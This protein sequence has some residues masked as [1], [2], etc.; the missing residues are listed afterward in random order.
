M[1]ILDKGLNCFQAHD[2]GNANTQDTQGPR[3]GKLRTVSD[4]GILGL[5][6]RQASVNAKAAEAASLP[7][8]AGTSPTMKKSDWQFSSATGVCPPPPELPGK[9]PARGGLSQRAGKLLRAQLNSTFSCFTQK[10]ADRREWNTPFTTH[11]RAG[12]TTTLRQF[13]Q[14]MQSLEQTSAV[15]ATND[16][17]RLVKGMPAPHQ[18]LDRTMGA[19]RTQVASAHAIA[20]SRAG[21]PRV[22]TPVHEN[23]L[24]GF[25]QSPGGQ[26]LAAKVSGDPHVFLSQID[27]MAAEHPPAVA[28]AVS[29][30]LVSS[31]G[32]HDSGNAT[33]LGEDIFHYLKNVD[34]RAE[35]GNAKTHSEVFRDTHVLELRAVRDQMKDTLVANRCTPATTPIED[36]SSSTPL[37]TLDAKALRTFTQAVR[38]FPTAMRE[39]VR[40]APP[41]SSWPGMSDSAARLDAGNAGAAAAYMDALDALADELNAQRPAQAGNDAIPVSKET[42]GKIRDAQEAMI[43]F[44]SEPV[45]LREYDR[46]LK[47]AE[48]GRAIAWGALQRAATTSGFEDMLAACGIGGLNAAEQNNLRIHLQAGAVVAASLNAK[49]TPEALIAARLAACGPMSSAASFAQRVSDASA[50]L[51][52]VQG[53]RPVILSA[54]DKADLLAWRNGFTDDGP[55]SKLSQFKKRFFKVLTWIDRQS[56]DRN[57]MLPGLHKSP[58]SAARAGI[59]GGDRAVLAAEQKKL[60]D[61]LS[62]PEVDAVVEAVATAMERAYRSG[63]EV[64]T[65]GAD[66]DGHRPAGLTDAHHTWIALRVALDD[67]MPQ[68][69]SGRTV[70]GLVLGR[71][72]TSEALPETVAQRVRTHCERAVISGSPEEIEQAVAH[73]GQQLANVRLG[74][75]DLDLLATYLGVERSNPFDTALQS[76]RNIASALPKRPADTTQQSVRDMLLDFLKDI[77]GGNSVRF[78]RSNAGGFSTKGITKNFLW[79]PKHLGIPVAASARVDLRYERAREAAVSMALPVHAAELFIGTE[80]RHRG[81]IAAGGF[82]GVKLFRLF[83]AGL[84]ADITPYEHERTDATGVMLRIPRRSAATDNDV[85]KLFSRIAGFLF[86]AADTRR[87]STDSMPDADAF[88]RAFADQFHGEHDLSISWIEQKTRAHRSEFSTSIA[89]SVSKVLDKHQP[90]TGSLGLGLGYAFEKQWGAKFTQ[91][92]ETGSFRIANLRHQKYSRHKL[93]LPFSAATVT[94]TTGNTTADLFGASTAFGMRSTQVKL[95]LALDRGNLLSLKSVADVEFDSAPD[96]IRYVEST[97]DE[98]ISM[99]AYPHRGDPDGGRTKGLKEVNEHI[100]KVRQLDTPYNAF[101]ARRYLTEDSANTLNRLRQLSLVTPQDAPQLHDQIATLSQNAINAPGSWLP[102]GLRAYEKYNEADGFNVNAGLRYAQN[103]GL[104]VERQLVF[105][106]IGPTLLKQ[107]ELDLQTA[108]APLPPV[109]SPDRLAESQEN[110]AGSGTAPQRSTL[111]ELL[112]R[113]RA[114]PSEIE[115]GGE[116]EAVDPIAPLAQFRQRQAELKREPG[117]LPKLEIPEGTTLRRKTAWVPELE[118][119]AEQPASNEQASH[120]PAVAEIA[121]E[122]AHPMRRE[123]QAHRHEIQEGK[124]PQTGESSMMETP[125]ADS[126]DR[127]E[128]RLAPSAGVNRAQILQRMQQHTQDKQ[129]RKQA[130]QMIQQLQQHPDSAAS[131]SAHPQGD[132][133]ARYSST[134]SART[135]AAPVPSATSA[136]ETE[137]PRKKKILGSVKLEKMARNV[138]KMAGRVK[139][140]MSTP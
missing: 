97:K 20:G 134:V 98:W 57:P 130:K 19:L 128:L 16:A 24:I 120:A 95:R 94:G 1:K 104:R 113:D 89:G 56:N 61:L 81:R 8:A 50:K 67:W 37:Q 117:R 28:L 132:Q 74:F 47:H 13:A 51:V 33:T 115:K 87:Q 86:S 2:T 26:E 138:K 90:Q 63:Q 35:I 126:V 123:K 68:H 133:L 62:K 38:D 127:R 105:D 106:T 79:F 83:R 59:A 60:M 4:G 140:A 40:H 102:V 54:S 78:S 80:G 112:R 131:T 109:T 118:P 21:R 27:T 32:L 42:A 119:I 69:A 101:F 107:R 12:R 45:H 103:T 58:L 7:G 30:A 70:Q 121:A 65:H 34:L 85:R 84:T 6:S 100:E 55:G 29:L 71:Q 88:F 96:Y 10:G 114:R 99:F 41:L 17:Q 66:E 137:A 82:F 108:L 11:A 23:G 48:S 110:R 135:V 92:D 46:C 111:A 77:P 52:T 5:R 3:A 44:V 31:K 122:P 25:W 53:A 136:T 75:E 64:G 36:V 73:V 9:P 91:I 18:A 39:T 93:S 125:R 139:K 43:S 76:A 116:Q 49:P 15:P 14:T 124:Q 72:F 22:D 129:E